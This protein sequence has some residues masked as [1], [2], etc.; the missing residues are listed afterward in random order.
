MPADRFLHPRA[1][2]STKVTLL[3]DLEYRAWTQYLLSADDFGVMRALPIAFQNDN[4]HLANRPAKVLQRC[5]DVLVR[6]GLVRAFEHQGKP[7]IYQHDWQHW[8]KVEY[9]RATNNPIPDDLSACD[10]STRALFAKHPGGQRKDRRRSEDVPNVS[11][12]NSEGDPPTRAW[13]RETA[14]AT[15]TANGSGQR[16]TANGERPR[17]PGARQGLMRGPRPDAA[18]DGGRVWVLHKTHQDFLALRNGN[19]S[20]LL[21]W[22]A[23]VAE[24]WNFGERKADEPGANMFKFWEARYAEQWPVAAPDRASSKLPPWV[25]KARAT[26]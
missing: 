14:T 1:G 22:Y 9:P 15:A 8:Q 16:L 10:D 17:P 19:E 4:D 3:T 5:I 24:A 26:V 12:T 6:A 21:T 11:Q 18:F 25:Q 13:A 2:H 20:E 7:F 23:D